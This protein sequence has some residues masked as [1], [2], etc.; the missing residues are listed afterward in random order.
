MTKVIIVMNG[1]PRAGKTTL[2]DSLI[3]ENVQNVAR[4]SSITPVKEAAVHLGWD[5][6]KTPK[7]RALLSELKRL[8]TETY[9][10]PMKYILS[11]VQNFYKD[12]NLKLLFIEIREAD[13]IRK[14]VETL[15]TMDMDIQTY[16]MYIERVDENG[17][18]VN[19]NPVGNAS[20][21]QALY[22]NYSYDYLFKNVDTNE[23]SSIGN[24]K[25][26]FKTWISRDLFPWLELN[27]VRPK[28]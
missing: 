1:K 9:N 26:N 13:Q 12:K 28:E 18:A 11:N 10:G 2:M 15:G 24:A 17:N 5:R 21:D 27:I 6:I 23:G 20:D 3:F 14:F 25:L 4:I 8:S 19:N 7:S 16:T 22:E